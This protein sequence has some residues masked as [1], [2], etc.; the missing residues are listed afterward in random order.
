MPEFVTFETEI[1]DGYE[2]CKWTKATH[3]AIGTCCHK[4]G[5]G[6]W[7]IY[8]G[9]LFYNGKP[10]LQSDDTEPIRF[11]PIRKKVVEP[12]RIEFKFIDEHGRPIFE[13]FDKNGNNLDVE[14][15][16][17]KKFLEVVE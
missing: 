7:G 11:I 14:A 9:R 15:L 4:I 8:Y 3:I 10:F 13:I 1:P 2:R 6:P 5:D 16:V 12:L 17:G